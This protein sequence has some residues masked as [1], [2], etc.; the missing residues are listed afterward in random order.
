MGRNTTRT[1][2]SCIFDWGCYV[3]NQWV[4]SVWVFGG[5]IVVGKAERCIYNEY[6]KDFRYRSC[7]GAVSGP[8]I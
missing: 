1:D 3:V 8:G 5:H 6:R 7:E 2:V 4:T